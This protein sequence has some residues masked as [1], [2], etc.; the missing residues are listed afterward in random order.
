MDGFPRRVSLK[1]VAKL[2]CRFAIGAATLKRLCHPEQQ[3]DMQLRQGTATLGTPALAAVLRQQLTA[4]SSEC[5][6][7]RCDFPAAQGVLG[8]LLELVSVD[9]DML[10]VEDEHSIR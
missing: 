3:P 6:L 10:G 4:V 9:Y 1:D 2:V 7:E 8:Q 5:S